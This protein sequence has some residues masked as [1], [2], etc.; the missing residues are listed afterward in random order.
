MTTWLRSGI[1]RP[2]DARSVEIMR[3]KGES[4]WGGFSEVE[5]DFV[6]RVVWGW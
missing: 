5:V 3:W 2:R 4:A 1:S 6:R